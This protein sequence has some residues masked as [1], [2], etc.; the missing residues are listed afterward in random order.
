MLS[1]ITQKAYF[2]ANGDIEIS[3]MQKLTETIKFIINV[4]LGT[5]RITIHSISLT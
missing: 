2:L 1:E 4:K 3:Q 5:H